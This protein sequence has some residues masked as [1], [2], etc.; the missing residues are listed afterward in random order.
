MKLTVACIAK[1]QKDAYALECDHFCKLARSLRAT[2]EVR[3]LFNKEV[4]KGHASGL[5][6]QSQKAYT[7]LFVPLL[8]ACAIALDPEGKSLDSFEFAALLDH[9]REVCF[10]IGGAYGL[11][12][13]FLSRCHHVVSLSP[14]TFS[15]KL[16]KLVLCEQIYR[17]L[18]I[19]GGH[20]YHKE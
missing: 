20:P 8:G 6:G 7:Q 9:K 13:S 11:E 4:A 19:L 14:M 1:A 17:G 3:E 10:F 5:A 18:S 15:H 12:Q 2:L 16:A